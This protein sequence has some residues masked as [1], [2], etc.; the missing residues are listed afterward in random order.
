MGVRSKTIPDPRSRTKCRCQPSNLALETL[1]CSASAG[2][3]SRSQPLT[4]AVKTSQAHATFA[5]HV[6]TGVANSLSIV[7]ETTV[8]SSK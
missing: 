8:A 1:S 3:C 7:R 4:P 2:S 5:F 6:S